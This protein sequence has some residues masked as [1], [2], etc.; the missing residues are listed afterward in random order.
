MRPQRPRVLT[1]SG[2]DAA[3][4]A[5]LQKDM[6]EVF[7]LYDRWLAMRG[8]YLVHRLMSMVDVLHIPLIRALNEVST[9]TPTI[10]LS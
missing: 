2:H 10:N 6:A 3:R 1:G 4:Y 7:D 8:G 9:P 5:K